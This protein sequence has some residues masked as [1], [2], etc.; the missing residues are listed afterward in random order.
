MS[1]SLSDKRVRFLHFSQVKFPEKQSN[2]LKFLF[3]FLSD[4]IFQKKRRYN[5]K[6]P[7]GKGN[8]CREVKMSALRTMYE[9]WRQLFTVDW[10]EETIVRFDSGGGDWRAV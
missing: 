1:A 3:K 4:A 5:E 9:N 10:E 8:F 2:L 7:F 6:N